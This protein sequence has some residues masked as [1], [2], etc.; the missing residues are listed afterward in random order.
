MKF[1][2]VFSSSIT[3]AAAEEVA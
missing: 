3:E 2:A 1:K